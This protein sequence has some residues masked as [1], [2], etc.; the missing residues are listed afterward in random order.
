MLIEERKQVPRCIPPAPPPH[1]PFPLQY[2][3]PILGGFEALP[4]GVMILIAL[5]ELRQARGGGG[6]SSSQHTNLRWIPSCEVLSTVCRSGANPRNY[7][8]RADVRLPHFL[9]MLRHT[10]RIINECSIMGFEIESTC[11]TA[12][13]VQPS[14]PTGRGPIECIPL[15]DADIQ[16]VSRS[17]HKGRGRYPSRQ[18]ALFQ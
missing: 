5:A 6:G 17:T 3:V 11:P 2:L 4:C 7:I 13:V 8:L 10:L 15:Q 16:H 1:A 18:S 9:P 14:A 12:G